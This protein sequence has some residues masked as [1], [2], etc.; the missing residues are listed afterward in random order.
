LRRLLLLLK[1]RLKL[2]LLVKERRSRVGGGMNL[3]LRLVRKRRL[4][5]RWRFRRV[6]RLALLTKKIKSAR[7]PGPTRRPLHPKVTSTA[8]SR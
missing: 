1:L 4:D 7:C 3:W 5:R 8:Q 2:E 6:N